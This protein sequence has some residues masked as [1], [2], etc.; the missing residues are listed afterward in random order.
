MAIINGRFN[1]KVIVQNG[2]PHYVVLDMENNNEIHCEF[3]ELNET[4]WELE[5]V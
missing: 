4:I 1:V 3:N 2:R 5:G